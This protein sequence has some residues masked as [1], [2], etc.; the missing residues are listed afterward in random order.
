MRKSSACPLGL[1]RSFA[2]L[3]FAA[4]GIGFRPRAGLCSRRSVG[5]EP[6]LGIALELASAAARALAESSAWWSPLR[7]R[8][9][10]LRANFRLGFASASSRASRSACSLLASSRRSGFRLGALCARTASARADPPSLRGLASSASRVPG[11]AAA[12]ARPSA[13]AASAAACSACVQSAPPHSPPRSHGPRTIVRALFG[14]SRFSTSRRDLASARA[15]FPLRAHSRALIRFRPKAFLAASAASTAASG[16]RFARFGRL[17]GSS[18]RRPAAGA[19]SP[20]ARVHARPR[21]LP[22]PLQCG[23]SPLRVRLPR[24][25]RAPLRPL[26]LKSRLRCA[27]QPAARARLRRSRAH[28]PLQALSA[29]RRS[30]P[31]RLRLRALRQQHGISRQ[32]LPRDRPF[33]RAADCCCASLSASRRAVGRFDC[34]LIGCGASV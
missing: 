8:V 19:R 6:R 1:D 3:R 31:S 30:A 24:P 33:L 23:L 5:Y 14:R 26:R 29:R 27:P 10:R 21:A 15:A 12:V 17:V 20:P 2:R 18:A 9:K 4:R 11:R 32:L 7:A 22:A 34:L 13:S 25:L 28:A 16:A